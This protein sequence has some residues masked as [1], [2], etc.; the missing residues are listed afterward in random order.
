[1]SEPRR[2]AEAGVV[3]LLAAA[4]PGAGEAALEAAGEQVL[5]FAV[6]Y[7]LGPIDARL[8]Q[9]ALRNSDPSQRVASGLSHV[10]D[11]VALW[12]D[13]GLRRR[14]RR[15]LIGV[16]D[17]VR[18]AASALTCPV[19]EWSCPDLDTVLA[20]AGD[21]A[22]LVDLTDSSWLAG[23]PGAVNERFASGERDG[24][25]GSGDANLYTQA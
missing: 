14:T 12:T 24:W 18:I 4:F 1:M 7:L 20:V 9:L 11:E 16:H 19:E 5:A 23:A 22:V 6:D 15:H 25:P 21:R 2:P 10:R 3:N 17:A 8:D 13:P